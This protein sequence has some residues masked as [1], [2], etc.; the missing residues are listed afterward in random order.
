MDR[1]GAGRAVGGAVPRLERAHHRRVLPAQRLGP[2]SSTSTAGSSAIVDNYEHLSFNVGPDAAV[3][4]RG[5]P[6]RGLRPHRR[7]RRARPAGAIAQAYNHADPAA[8]QRARRAHAGPVGAGRLRPPLRPPR[9]GHV[10]AGDRGQR[11]RARACSPRRASASR[12]SPPSQ[13]RRRRPVAIDSGDGA[14]RW[15]A[16]RAAAT[17]SVDLVFYDGRSRH[18]LA[19]GLAG[20]R[21]R[22]LV[23]PGRCGRRRRRHA[24]RASPPTARP[25]ATTTSS[26]T[27]RWP[28]PSPTRRPPRRRRA[29]RSRDWL[30]DAP[31]DRRGPGARERVVVRP[32]RRAVEGGLRLPHRRRAGLEP[33]VAGAA[34]RR[35]RRAPRRRRRGVRAPGR[36][37]AATTRGRPATPT[38]TCSSARSTIERL[39]RRARARARDL[40]EALTLLEAQRHAL[41]MYTSCGWFFNDLAGHRDRAGPA[42]RR[43]L[44]DLLAELGEDAAARR[45]SSTCSADA[46][47]QPTGGGRRPRHLAPPRRAE[48]GRRRAGR[49]PPRA[50]RPARAATSDVERLARPRRRRPRRHRHRRP[51][52]PVGLRRPSSSSSHRRTRRRSTV[53]LRRRPPRRASRSSARVRPRRRAGDDDAGAVDR[54]DRRRRPTATR[55]TDAAAADRRGVRAPEFGL[56]A[57]LPDAAGQIVESAATRARRPVRGRLRAAAG[58]PPRDVRRARHR[59]LPAAARAAGAGRVRARPAARGRGGRRRRRRRPSGA[60]RRRAATARV[61]ARAGRASTSAS[62]RA[63]PPRSPRPSTGRSPSRSPS[64]DDATSTTAVDLLH[65][66]PA[67]SASSSTS[68]APQ[69]LVYDA[70][71]R[72]RTLDD[73]AAA[74]LAPARRRRCGARR[75]APRPAGVGRA[76]AAA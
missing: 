14:Y 1:G 16:P 2:R 18:D 39:R 13:A 26:P 6:P 5:A 53:R 43:P 38:S 59:R 65:A 11:R 17:R 50:R 15:V 62:P 31:A 27:G 41:L 10:A 36:D 42:L 76:R 75:G 71:R 69:E 40:V 56:E 64:R 47:Q 63:R 61:A 70:P 60:Y 72:R 35:A 19:F 44:L 52:R 66:R 4:A 23:A 12:S 54:L 48:P 9:R 55:V 21:A 20:S 28:T 22:T 29:A 7:G 3:V 8:G 34:A 58:R 73:D 25:S 51:G 33:G 67:S 45:S 68:T 57:A 30:A 74:P 24:G 32:R 46:P 49:R 37:G